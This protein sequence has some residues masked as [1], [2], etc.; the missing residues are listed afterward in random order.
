MNR[1]EFIKTILLPNS[2]LVQMYGYGE[3]LHVRLVDPAS[4]TLQIGT[5]LT[6]DVADEAFGHVLED[7]KGY[8]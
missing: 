4:R 2:Y 5:Y 3:L 8:V 1:V 6:Y 7:A